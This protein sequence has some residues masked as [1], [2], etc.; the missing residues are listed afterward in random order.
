MVRKLRKVLWRQVTEFPDYE[1]S[2][3]GKVRR[4][5]TSVYPAGKVLKPFKHPRGYLR[6]ELWRNGKS[7]K[8]SAHRLVAVAF[9][10]PPPTSKHEAAHGDGDPTNNYWRNLR[11]ATPKENYSDRYTH[12]TDQYGERNWC[13]KLNAADVLRIRERALFGA[14]TNE[15]ARLFNVYHA[16][17]TDI[18][19]RRSWAHL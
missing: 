8:R 10:G 5:T 11:W 15:T 3:F 12:G 17:I 9:L 14:G 19:K 6:Y 4:L 2:E 7:F 18:V 16:T 13:V 1:V